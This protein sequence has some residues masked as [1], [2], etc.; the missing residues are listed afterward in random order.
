MKDSRALSTRHI[1][2]SDCETQASLYSRS[3]QCPHCCRRL[4]KNTI[5]LLTATITR[6]SDTHE[7]SWS[8]HG[9]G[10]NTGD[11]WRL[12]VLFESLLVQRQICEKRLTEKHVRPLVD[13][14]RDGAFERVRNMSAKP[15]GRGSSQFSDVQ[16]NK[17]SVACLA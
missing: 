12:P 17:L 9:S 14:S 10:D 16:S 4:T 15:F 2:S 8:S 5:I 13:A 6:C 11:D 3:T 7:D 1:N